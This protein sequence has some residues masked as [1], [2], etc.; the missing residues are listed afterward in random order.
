M[1]SRQ[2]PVDKSKC[3]ICQSDTEEPLTHLTDKGLRC[4]VNSCVARKMPALESH[5]TEGSGDIPHVTHSTCRKRFTDLRKVQQS[6]FNTDDCV[7]IK[8]LRSCNDV[9]DWKR[10]CFLCKM[11][12]DGDSGRSNVRTARTIE[13]RESVLNRCALRGDDWAL[14]VQGRLEDCCDLV[15]PEAVYHSYCDTRFFQGRD[16]CRTGTAGR[17]EDGLMVDAFENT[18]EWLESSCEDQLYTFDELRQYMLKYV[19]DKYE[20]DTYET[21]EDSVYSMKHL[22]DK[23]KSKYG[24]NVYFAEVSGR[25]NVLCFRN[26]CSFLINDKWYSDRMQDCDRDSERIV[27]TA[28]KLIASEIRNMHCDLN[29]Y[30]TIADMQ[31]GGDIYCFSV[32]AVNYCTVYSASS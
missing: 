29:C 17:P 28:A 20:T 15:H 6:A 23:L 19:T 1:Y 21:L 11:P 9:F 27:K 2:G 18:C 13:L 32:E 25:K 26:L 12:A 24:D 3:I 5:L 7:P 8:R 4:I 31:S 14:D 22:K 10:M 30:P 16:L